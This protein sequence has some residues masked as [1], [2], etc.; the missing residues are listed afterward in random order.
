M[1]LRKLPKGIHTVRRKLSNG[2]NRFHFYAWRGGPKFWVDDRRFPEDTEFF[3][4]YTNVT[5]RKNPNHLIRQHWSMYF[6][7][8]PNSKQK[9]KNSIRLQKMVFEVCPRFLSRSRHRDLK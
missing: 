3:L 7:I 1:V 8:Q 6:S 9:T 4:E 2:T 5:T